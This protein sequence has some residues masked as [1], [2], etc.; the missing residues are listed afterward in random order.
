M[1]LRNARFI[2]EKVTS[3][4]QR[5]LRNYKDG[6]ASINAFLDDYAFTI[7]AFISLYQITFDETWLEDAKLLADYTIEHFFDPESGMFFYTSDVDPGLIARKME[8]TDNV[9]PASNSEM[10]KNLFL[11]GTYFYHDDY[12]NISRQMLNNVKS[13]ALE[14]GAYYANWDMLM[15]WFASP[16]YE[17]AI[18]GDDFETIR[19]EFNTKYLPNVFFSGG[20][21]EG[22]LSLLKGKLINGQTTIYV[23]R[24]KT[25]KLPVTD[26]NE[27]LEQISAGNSSG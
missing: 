18:L 7:G 23:C 19:K 5:L 15:A 2:Q 6:R 9:I 27:A 3:D 26:I 13:G 21:R 8:V 25:C 14:G 20:N 17:V 22:N 11:L 4:D 1:A 24:D 16:P 12:I 10:A